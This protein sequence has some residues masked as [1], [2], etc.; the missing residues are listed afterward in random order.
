MKEQKM[1]KISVFL[2]DWQVLFREGIHF[3]LSGE[4]DVEV[5][6]ETINNEDA[7]AFIQSNPPRVAVLNIDHDKLSGIDAT[8]YLRQNFPSVAMIL[9]MDSNN[10]DHLFLA[11][12]S[13]AAACLT[14]D[15][16][17]DELVETVRSVAH[18]GQPIGENLLRPEI[19]SRVLGEFEEF[20]TISKQI[21]NLL[22]RLA[23][24]EAELLHN[25][26]EGKSIEQICQNL[27]TD[28]ES[29][30]RHFGF[31]VGKLVSNDHNREVIEAAQ[32][33]VLSLVSRTRGRRGK[34][35]GDY[36]T[37]D[38]FSAFKDSLLERFRSII[39]EI[40]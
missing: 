32:K 13:G 39:G 37:K 10:D 25:L 6:G 3:T 21:D 17:P 29:I 18:G 5:I 11:M 12:K 26:A 19:A 4:E 1:D 15:T 2:A 16:D 30:R 7:L 38:E 35:S 33:D 20:T 23:P 14:K 9:I 24:S 8:R 22:A 31:I 27:N 28:E 34:P 36:I 40:K